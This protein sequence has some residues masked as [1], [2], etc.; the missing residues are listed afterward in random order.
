MMVRLAGF[1]VSI[2]EQKRNTMD[3]IKLTGELPKFLKVL[4]FK[5]FRW[6]LIKIDLN[7]LVDVAA[8]TEGDTLFIGGVMGVVSIDFAPRLS[9]KVDFPVSYPPT[10]RIQKVGIVVATFVSLLYHPVNKHELVPHPMWRWQMEK[11]YCCVEMAFL[12]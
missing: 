6:K 7:G 11:V 8:K 12:H 9:M 2:A 1:D 3:M 5:N 10:T 4:G